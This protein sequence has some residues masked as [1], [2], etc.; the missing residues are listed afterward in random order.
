MRTRSLRRGVLPGSVHA[1][2]LL[3]HQ[4]KGCERGG[5]LVRAAKR[6]PS[7]PSD[8]LIADLL[9]ARDRSMALSMQLGGLRAS[10][11]RLLPLP[12]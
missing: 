11:V 7:W 1:A 9:I 8:R 12:S 6:P 10:E 2:G 4:G 3:V 5:R